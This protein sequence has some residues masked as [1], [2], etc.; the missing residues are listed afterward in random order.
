MTLGACHEQKEFER[1][2]RE[3]G[4]EFVSMNG[5]SITLAISCG[6]RRYLKNMLS[7]LR[8]ALAPGDG[9]PKDTPRKPRRRQRPCLR[10]T[11]GKRVVVEFTGPPLVLWG[12]S[13]G[14]A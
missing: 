6:D 12:S 14:P 9:R 10:P 4:A 11:E 3:F 7:N 13:L 1:L 8:R 5:A 2:L